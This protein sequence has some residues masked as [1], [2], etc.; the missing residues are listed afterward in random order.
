MKKMTMGMKM[1]LLMKLIDSYHKKKLMFKSITTINI[2]MMKNKREFN[3]KKKDKS[4]KK[5]KIRKSKKNRDI[6]TNKINSINNK[7]RNLRTKVE[8]INKRT[9]INIMRNKRL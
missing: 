4:K 6:K 1:K 7:I 8:I 3:Q 5:K 2:K 9:S